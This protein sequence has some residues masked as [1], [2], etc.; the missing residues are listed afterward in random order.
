MKIG[1]WQKIEGGVLS[2]VLDSQSGGENS[3][4][5][6]FSVGKRSLLEAMAH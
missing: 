5:E 6:Y 3:A 4:D 1:S 2:R